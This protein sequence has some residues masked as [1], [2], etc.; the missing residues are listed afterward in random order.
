MDSLAPSERV[1]ELLREGA[2][3]ILNDPQPWL[4]DIDEATFAATKM[5][6]VADDPTLTAEMRRAIRANLLAWAAANVRS[7]GASV[8]ANVGAEPLTIARDLARRGLTQSALQAYRI[9]QNVMWQ[10]WMP[11]AFALTS[12]PG[13]LRELLE[14]SAQSLFSFISDTNA[15][16]AA[17]MRIE[18]EEL[19]RGT[20]AER[21]ETVELLLAGAP[22]AKQRAAGRLGYNLDQAHT[23][24][25]V[26]SSEP[27]TDSSTIDL[28][29]EAF[30][31]SAEVLRPL[32]VT[33]SA[34]TRWVWIPGK[35]APDVG[36]LRQAIQDVPGVRVAIGSTA[37]G[38][39]GFRRSHFDALTTQRMMARLRTEERIASFHTV[40]L[41][42]LVTYDTDRADEF[43]KHTLGA[44]ESASAELRK[45]VLTFVNEQCNASR[46]AARLYTHRNTLLRRLSRADELLPQP[47][48]ENCVN[49]AVA[50]GVL[51]WRGG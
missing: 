23:A 46:A 22:I 8:P 5:E 32:S 48:E 27:E 47:L 20:H 4:D 17:Q 38:I 30:A 35:V 31:R 42:S 7:P 34:T 6:P 13:E 45:T 11:V 14:V 44:F 50:L 21:R 41:I 33:A 26:W 29:S 2:K 15:A 25:I 37:A 19:T 39:E 28:A 16:I 36:Q 9:S 12:D 18:R 40:E 10:R 49:V 1:R 24:A 3:T 43:I 51:H